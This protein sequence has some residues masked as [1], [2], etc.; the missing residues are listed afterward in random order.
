MT[1]SERGEKGVRVSVTVSVPSGMPS[2]GASTTTQDCLKSFPRATM[3]LG[4]SKSSTGE[5]EREREEGRGCGV[6]ELK[7]YELIIIQKIG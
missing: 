2:E 5:R 4:M 7:L 3:L 6:G 1:L